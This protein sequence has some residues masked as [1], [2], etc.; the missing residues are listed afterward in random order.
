VT[1]MCNRRSTEN[2]IRC[3]YYTKGTGRGYLKMFYQ[4]VGRENVPV[5]ATQVRLKS[6]HD[7]RY[8]T[9]PYLSIKFYMANLCT[10]YYNKCSF[11][12]LFA[13]FV[14]CTQ[15]LATNNCMF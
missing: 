15:K 10:G 2:A 3:H 4:C 6:D 8:N 12:P 5:V 11:R 1:A 9:Q 14:Q 13:N 7:H